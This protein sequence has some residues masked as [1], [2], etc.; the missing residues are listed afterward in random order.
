[1]PQNLNYFFKSIFF[2]SLLPYLSFL[3]FIPSEIVGFGLTGWAWMLCLFISIHTILN[4]RTFTFPLKIWMPW[5]LYISI[6]G[7]IDFSFFGIQ[8]TLQ[9]LVPILV[10]CAAATFSYSKD[11]IFKLFTLF[12]KL[13]IVIFIIT[14]IK[15]LIG[16]RHTGAETVMFL[17]IWATLLL[18][19]FFYSG[20]KKYLKYYG[21][22][23]FIPFLLVTRM[24][25]A[26]MLAVVPLHFTNRNIGSKIIFS[27]LIMLV[28]IWLFNTSTIQEK[29][30]YDGQGTIREL[31]SG[32]ADLNTSGR[33]NLASLME[34]GLE[35][36]PV[37]GMGPRADLALFESN[38][39]WIKEAHNDYL[40]VRYNYGWVGL[41]LLLFS[42]LMQFISLFKLKDFSES[43][44]YQVLWGTSL[45]LF[46]PYL[47]FMYSD[48]ILK[49]STT[50]GNFFFI[51]LGILFSIKIMDFGNNLDSND[52]SYKS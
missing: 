17:V 37:W 1:M 21:L 42:M 2:A 6:Y 26:M 40:S 47:G 49:Y 16:Q 7:L 27:L 34:P 25:I 31:I 13:L 50:Y 51:F 36:N 45:T 5:I 29:M 15:F 46:I 33:S 38:G 19:L 23:A 10:G 11:I 12:K 24:G 28:S 8:L 43:M 41:G 30:F 52:K 9:Y 22:L 20:N 44:E 32:E 35:K 48:N 3:P 4:S 18:S 39:L 14:I